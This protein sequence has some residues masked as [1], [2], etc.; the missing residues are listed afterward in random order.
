VIDENP[1]IDPQYPPEYVPPAGL[2][3]PGSVPTRLVKY[4]HIDLDE[5]IEDE[6][7]REQV[8][9]VLEGLAYAD[10]PRWDELFI[11]LESGG[12]QLQL[13]EDDPVQGW[14]YELLDILAEQY[15]DAVFNIWERP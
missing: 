4:A 1:P 15:A 2:P 11:D 14:V 3:E 8:W 9:E 13:D 12:Y 7:L 10:V 5:A 6:G